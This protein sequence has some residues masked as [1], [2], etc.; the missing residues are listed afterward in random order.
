MESSSPFPSLS[1]LFEEINGHHF[2]SFLDLPVLRWNPR[3]RASAGRFVPGSRKYWQIFRPAIEVA[4][5]LLEERNSEILIKDTLSHEMIHYWLWIRRKPYGHTAEF[6]KKMKEM[7]VNR[8]NPVPRIRPNRYVY[9]CP[10]CQKAFF[11]K[12]KLGPLACAQCCKKYSNGRYDDRF[13][14]VL[15]RILSPSLETKG[16]GG[17]LPETARGLLP[18]SE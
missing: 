1:L 11:A 8:Y 15:D 10:H 3:L 5:Y 12:R 17:R 6:I 7:G 2:E 13:K 14:L 18:Y 9:L 4:S 16:D